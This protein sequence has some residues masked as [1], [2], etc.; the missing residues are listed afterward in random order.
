MQSLMDYQ[1]ICLVHILILDRKQEVLTSVRQ[2]DRPSVGSGP[3]SRDRS[4][5]RGHNT[6]TVILVGQNRWTNQTGSERHR[7]TSLCGLCVF[8]WKICDCVC[9]WYRQTCVF[10]WY[11]QMC[12]RVWHRQKVVCVIS[13]ST[14]MLIT[15]L[16]SPLWHNPPKRHVGAHGTD[17]RVRVLARC[18]CV[19]L[20]VCEREGLPPLLRGVLIM[21]EN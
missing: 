11:R 14:G 1:Q 20:C 7:Q 10:V 9:V 3:A 16:T 5:V 8:E 15:P 21:S 12:V 4:K 6:N 2:G 17:R 13:C 18:V 19:C